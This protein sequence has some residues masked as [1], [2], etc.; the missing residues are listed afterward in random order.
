MKKFC[1]L[2]IAIVTAFVANAQKTV[3]GHSAPKPTVAEKPTAL[4][5]TLTMTN[6]PAIHTSR[7]LYPLSPAGSG[8]TT[9][10]NV[11]NDKGFAE[12]YS[13]NAGDS[14][15]NVIGV[16]AVFGGSVS[17]SSTQTITLKLWNKSS[18]RMIT[19]SLYHEGVP[20]TV[21][22][23]LVVPATGLGIG[24]SVD[25]IKQF[26][27]PSS[28]GFLKDDFFAGYTINYNFPSIG[29]DTIA[30]K[31]SIDGA[32]ATPT[33][34]LSYNKNAAG[35]TI[36]VDTLIYVQNATL[37][38][39]GIWHDNFTENDSMYYN[40]AIFPIV[41]IGGPTGVGQVSRHELSLSGAYPN[42]AN[43]NTNIRFSLS[44]PTSVTITIT[45][46]AGRTVETQANMQLGTGVHHV[47]VN[48]AHLPTGSY[49]YL[50]RTALGS[51]LAGKL[52]VA[53]N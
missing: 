49:I 23:S 30:L 44:T 13:F 20:Y 11:Y 7:V 22:D 47:A 48:T 3:L 42:P 29:A 21:I 26:M 9:G 5:D 16:M 36:S 40:L 1:T 25:T 51:G 33:H 34:K 8:Y 15:V 6:I 39:D 41:V 46:M 12:R 53:H 18:T 28:T 17:P 27:F 19:S 37:W 10:T 43:N 32:R 50:V 14:S 35:D 2:A 38:S 4:G 52:Q 31:T 24:A 45:D